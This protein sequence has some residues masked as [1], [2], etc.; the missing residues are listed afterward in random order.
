MKIA[1]RERFWGEG[2]HEG[3][4]TSVR[5]GTMQKRVTAVAVS[6]GA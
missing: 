1:L 4:W 3:R 5:I 2:I 6:K